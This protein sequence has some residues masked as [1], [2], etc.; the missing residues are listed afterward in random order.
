MHHF[1]FLLTSFE[2]S[3]SSTSLSAFNCLLGLIFAILMGVTWYLTVVLIYVSL[4]TNVGYLF[5]CLLAIYILWRNM[6]SDIFPCFNWV[7][8][9]FIIELEEF[10]IQSRY[11]YF[12]QFYKLSFY[13]LDNVI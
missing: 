6:Y 11:V 13:L 12:L 5:M 7:I 10:F 4:I 1:I 3:S 8:C 2:G 9:I